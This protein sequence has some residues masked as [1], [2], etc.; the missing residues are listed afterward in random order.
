MRHSESYI[1]NIASKNH[2]ADQ[3]HQPTKYAVPASINS[4]A[5]LLSILSSEL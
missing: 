1:I 2:Q 4:A 5:V 3:P